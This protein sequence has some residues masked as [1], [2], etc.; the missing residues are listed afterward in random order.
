MSNFCLQNDTSTKHNLKNRASLYNLDELDPN[1]NSYNIIHNIEIINKKNIH[2]N[3]L[4]FILNK[5]QHKPY[6]QIDDIKNIYK[7]DSLQPSTIGNR[8]YNDEN[9]DNLN[10]FHIDNQSEEH[11]NVNGKENYINEI[12]VIDEVVDDIDVDIDLY[13]AGYEVNNT[14]DKHINDDTNTNITDD[15][16]SGKDNGENDK[17]REDE[18]NK[19]KN[20]KNREDED[21]K[22]K[23]DKNRED[24]DNKNK[25]DK[26]KSDKNKSDKN[27]ED[28][29]NKNKSDKNKSDKNGM[30]NENIDNKGEGWEKEELT[31]EYW[32]KREESDNDYEIYMENNKY[33]RTA[34]ILRESIRE[35]GYKCEIVG[36]I[37]NKKRI[38]IIT[39]RYINKILPVNVIIYNVGILKMGIDEK[40]MDMLCSYEIWDGSWDNIDFLSKIGI[41]RWRYVPILYNKVIEKEENDNKTKEKDIDILIYDMNKDGIEKIRQINDGGEKINVIYM[42][43]KIEKELIKRA[44]IVLQMNRERT[45]V[46]YELLLCCLYNKTLLCIEKLQ[47]TKEMKKWV[48]HIAF[49]Q[50]D[51]F[52]NL[53]KYLDFD[54]RNKLLN[55]IISY[56]K[57]ANTSSY[58]MQILGYDTQRKIKIPKTLTTK[59]ID[60]QVIYYDDNSIPCN[61]NLLTVIFIKDNFIYDKIPLHS[62]TSKFMIIMNYDRSLDYIFNVPCNTN[63]MGCYR[64]KF[65]EENIPS[66]M[67]YLKQSMN[68]DLVNFV[69]F[70]DHFSHNL[71]LS[72]DINQ[73]LLTLYHYSKQVSHITECGVRNGV[74]SWAFLYGLN[75]NKQSNKTLVSV[76][77]EP[78]S[79]FQS[80][81]SFS[82]SHDISF[83][84]IQTNDLTYNFDHTDLLFIDTW[85]VYGQLKR[86]L[87]KF[88]PKVKKYIILHDTSVDEFS[89]E[90]LRYNH[91]IS[92]LSSQTGIPSSEISL[93]LW[94]AIVEFLE[95]H[96]DFSLKERFTNC[97]GLVVLERS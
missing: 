14:K 12:D 78:C 15:E 70:K 20:D 57:L 41:R 13:N 5:P 3:N 93:G 38:L 84:F 33:E 47:E 35:M 60:K 49:L 61:S 71:Y 92:S 89:G 74:S 94:P 24:E 43:D 62:Q 37:N 82:V 54:I 9:M 8:C 45:H 26:N 44:K 88:Y 80:L 53:I 56:M 48:K 90:S 32:I 18:D 67:S 83:S 46:N 27:R 63:F 85:H 64:L 77:L 1:T 86:E 21:N 7:V 28:E 79:N 75:K 29:D 22:N 72:S 31:E 16:K 95:Q 4:Q 6:L 87:N 23:S 66:I 2:H 39:D 73:H 25:N 97:N 17:N 40:Y 42:G 10:L 76:D 50:S 36:N 68:F 52:Y 59:I 34:K 91:N 96:S 19:N 55:N 81:E 11:I 51:K 58:I 30:E 69:V 65:T